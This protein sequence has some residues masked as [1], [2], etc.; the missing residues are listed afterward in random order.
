MSGPPSKTSFAAMLVALACANAAHAGIVRRT[1]QVGA[2]VI[3]SARLSSTIVASGG[4]IE[5]RVAGHRSAPAALLVDGQ[6][7]A[8]G[9]SA[10]ILA[11]P[12]R[13]EV[14]VTVLY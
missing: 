10:A 4:A 6:A 7:K 1:F 9:E 11:I 14:V 8:I 2:F 3:H 5:I 12:L 13:G